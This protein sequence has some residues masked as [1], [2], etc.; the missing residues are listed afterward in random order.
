M[1][2]SERP[3]IFFKCVF[4]IIPSLILP[5]VLQFYESTRRPKVYICR[6]RIRSGMLLDEIVERVEKVFCRGESSFRAH[7]CALCHQC[8]AWVRNHFHCFCVVSISIT[9]RESGSLWAPRDHFI[10]PINEMS[11]AGGPVVAIIHKNAL[12]T[13]LTRDK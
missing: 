9:I 7:Q 1:I 2:I 8:R 3:S 10:H 12:V 6:H 11:F 4:H 5:C 13:K